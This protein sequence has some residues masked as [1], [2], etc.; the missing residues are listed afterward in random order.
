MHSQ[1]TNL[2]WFGGSR[3]RTLD[4]R[5]RSVIRIATKIVSFGPWAM[6]YPSKK[7]RQNPFT[8]LRVIR[9]TDRQTGRT[10]NITSFFGGGNNYDAGVCDWSDEVVGGVGAC[11]QRR[12]RHG[13]VC[14]LT[15]GVA[16]CV[17]PP[18]STCHRRHGDGVVG[19]LVCGSDNHTY[20]SS[21]QLLLFSCRLQKHI[22][23]K[24]TGPCTNNGLLLS[25]GVVQG[26]SSLFGLVVNDRSCNWI[27]GFVYQA[28]LCHAS[29]EWQRFYY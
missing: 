18:T 10:K 28:G 14:Q 8:S 5:I 17:C 11:A 29:S 27:A 4:S 6:A 26:R 20:G 24:H 23:L 9:R 16:E 19:G 7:F 1:R 13:A 22:S 2:R 15:N 21:C 25:T 12:C 3:L